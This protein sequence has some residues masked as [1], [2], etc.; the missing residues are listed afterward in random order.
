MQEHFK[1]LRLWDKETRTHCSYQVVE[2]SRCPT[3][4]RIKVSTRSALPPE[5]IVKRMQDKGWGMGQR[6]RNDLCP[7]C[8][9]KTP[10]LLKIAD[11]VRAPWEPTVENKK[12]VLHELELRYDVQAE[13]YKF[14]WS[15]EK[16]AEKTGAPVE[17]IH[18]ALNEFR[19]ILVLEKD[20]ASLRDRIL[21]LKRL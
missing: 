3:T 21:E 6:R 19:D 18:K 17:F 5:V 20:M 8:V 11:F 14:G 12:R 16:V 13:Q 15:A 1:P 2:C 4:E 9:K 7:S 10:T